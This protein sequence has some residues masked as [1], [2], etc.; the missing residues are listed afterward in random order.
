MKKVLLLALLFVKLT[1]WVE[2]QGTYIAHSN[3]KNFFAKYCSTDKVKSSLIDTVSHFMMKKAYAG[4]SSDDSATH[5]VI[6]SLTTQKINLGDNIHYIIR[7]QN[8]GT[9]TAFN[10]VIADTLN[11]LL[12]AST[13][14][15]L[16]SS[17][18]CRV[19]Q[20]GNVVYFE[21]LNIMLP[22][23]FESKT[24]SSGFV[25]YSAR[26]LKSILNETGFNNNANIYFDYN[27][28]VISNLGVAQIHE[29]KNERVK[30]IDFDVKRKSEEE[31]TISWNVAT[32]ANTYIYLVEQS[33]D[34]AN[35]KTI[36]SLKPNN[37]GKYTYLV[38]QS[39]MMYYRLRIVDYDGSVISSN[40]SLLKGVDDVDRMVTVYTNPQSCTMVL[41]VRTDRLENTSAFIVNAVGSVIKRNVLTAGIQTIDLTGVAKGLYYLNTRS[42]VKSF[43]VR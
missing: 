6:S 38:Q 19:K 21:F 2:A 35:F 39:E 23:N 22:D 17:H 11:A 27:N 32:E 13:F 36:K 12:D 30:L 15:V 3:F 18:T 33:L 24:Q 37:N 10:V 29:Q 42:G 5:Q 26:P 41:D 4:N 20:L 8:T 25:S 43:V 34:G 1:G 28:P 16:N 9:D 31:V 40:I 14:Q 7:F